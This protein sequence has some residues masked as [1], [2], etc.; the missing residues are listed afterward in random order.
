MELRPWQRRAR[1]AY[2]EQNAPDWLCEATPGAGKTKLALALAR[3]WL[4][5][6]AAARVVVVCPTAHLRRQW[7]HAAVQAGLAL[8]PDAPDGHTSPDFHGVV[9]TYQQ[10]AADPRPYALLVRSRPT[11]VIFDELHHA[12]DGLAWGDA[13]AQ[14]FGAAARRL[15]LSGTPFRSDAARIP[16]VCYGPDGLSCPDF[17]YGYEDALRDGVCRPLY[18]PAYGG[19][20]SWRRGEGPIRTA[21]F[22]DP[23]STA[24]QRDRLRAAI[25]STEWL[26]TVLAAAHER[27]VAVRRTDPDAGGLIIASTQD[28]ARTIAQLVASLTGTQPALAIS[29]DP[30]ASAALEQFSRGTRPWLVAVNMVSEGV[31]LPRLRVGV[32]A[33]TVTTA[34][35]FRQVAGRL[36]RRRPAETPHTPAWLYLPND[37]TLTAH[38]RELQQARRHALAPLPPAASSLPAASMDRAGSAASPFTALSGLAWTHDVITPAGMPG[39][40]AAAVPAARPAFDAR[41]Q[42]RTRHHRLVGAVARRWGLAHQLIHAELTRRTGT[43]IHEASL[44]Q[45]RQRLALLETWLA[46]GSCG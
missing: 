36:V 35:Y 22:Q 24:R 5:G 41:A 13:L 25:L 32:Y 29:D 2:H 16:F 28:H 1:A 18:F 23:L 31:D 3:D 43:R 27:L 30:A 7:A 9:L 20:V 46:Q 21:S 38:A 11:G 8:D 12:A 4:A 34:L 45:L 39:G 17:R 19:V 14:A 40:L 26:S 6:R 15:A 37:P 44:A 33:T 42:L 10:I